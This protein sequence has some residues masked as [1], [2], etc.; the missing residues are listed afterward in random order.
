LETSEKVRKPL[1]ALIVNRWHRL[2]C[3]ETEE[4]SGDE[5]LA[6]MRLTKI[7]YFQERNFGLRSMK[8]GGRISCLRKE[9]KE[10]LKSLI[11]L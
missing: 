6:K 8:P 1:I 3:A 7:Y 4:K 11:S 10:V 9:Q 5:G 2:E